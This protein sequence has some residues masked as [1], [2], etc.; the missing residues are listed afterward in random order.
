MSRLSAERTHHLPS[1]TKCPILALVLITLALSLRS[2]RNRSLLL[3]SR[4]GRRWIFL[5]LSTST[6]ILD[7]SYVIYSSLAAYCTSLCNS[8]SRNTYSFS[9]SLLIK[10]RWLVKR[11]WCLTSTSWTTST[12]STSHLHMSNGKLNSN[13]VSLRINHNPET[14]FI[15]KKIFHT[16]CPCNHRKC[17]TIIQ[18]IK[19]YAT[20]I[21][22][23]KISY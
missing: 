14:L 17:K 19:S 1:L 20:K 11:G 6:H 4:V 5:P 8:S 9:K 22:F 15:Y 13:A 18:Y 7:A 3:L 21:L 2:V 12:S 23:K 10:N 16:Q